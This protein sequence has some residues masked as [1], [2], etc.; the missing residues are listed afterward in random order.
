[1]Q[2]TA[3]AGAASSSHLLCKMQISE[4]SDRLEYR[5][6]LSEAISSFKFVVE[7]FINHFWFPQSVHSI[8]SHKLHIHFH[9]KPDKCRGVPSSQ[10]FDS[11][12]SRTQLRKPQS[13]PIFPLPISR[14]KSIAIRHLRETRDSPHTA[15]KMINI[16]TLFMYVL[17]T[18]SV[19]VIFFST[20]AGLEFE[21]NASSSPNIVSN[22]SL[23]NIEPCTQHTNTYRHSRGYQLRT[24]PRPRWQ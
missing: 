22:F 6:S 7:S 24:I 13:S 8:P 9:F 4:C 20:K 19:V 5:I 15:V 1:M 23:S 2:D 12:K 3:V 21:R 18:L 17:L 16:T 11:V 14:P 10:S